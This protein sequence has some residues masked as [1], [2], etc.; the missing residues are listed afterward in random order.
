M[1]PRDP[2]DLRAPLA[3]IL[4]ALDMPTPALRQWFGMLQRFIAQH[5]G[6][7]YYA[8]LADLIGAS[9]AEL[10]RRGRPAEPEGDA[11]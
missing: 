5:G 8:R 3:E 1:S 2:K 9:A 4:A 11:R 7:R 10:E 6:P